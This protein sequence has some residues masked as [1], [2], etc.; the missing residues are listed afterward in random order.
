MLKRKI[1][2]DLIQW[3]NRRHKQALLVEGARQVGKTT[4]IRSF[5]KQHYESFIELNFERN[6][7]LKD[8]F[9]DDLEPKTIYM[10]MS[11][12]GLGP[13]KPGKT[14][15]FFDEIQSCPQARTAIKFLVEDGRYDFI[16]SGSLLGINYKDVSS[17]PVG[18]EE[19][20]RMYS[21]D[22]EEF[23]WANHISEDVTQELKQC[24]KDQCPIPA[25]IHDKM[26]KLYYQ[27]LIVGGMPNVV[28]EFI[29]TYDI[30]EVIRIQKD[31]IASYRDNISKY[32]EGKKAKVKEI[33]EAIPEQL[34]KKNQRFYFSSLTAE[35]ALR[36]Y[37]GAI[38]WLND[39]G[40]ASMCCNVTQPQ[41]PLSFNQKRNLFKLFI[42]DSGF[43]TAMSYGRIQPNILK[44][45]LT[46]NNGAV[47][48]NDVAA[49]ILKK[50]FDIYYY[51]CKKPLQ[52]EIDFLIQYQ[53][54]ILPIKVKSGDD[55]KKH[56]SLDRF[57]SQ[58][59]DMDQ[60]IVFC[61][62]NIEKDGKLL[63]LP[64]YMTGFLENE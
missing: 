45:E 37:E 20:I 6:P 56:P 7:K 26:M 43:L 2:S 12:M 16:E 60:A 30:N 25:F 54:G 50:G 28:N 24:F 22:F 32:A 1:E 63:Y 29:E 3:K 58:Y 15:I 4:S 59:A 23:M 31:I 11:A 38:T 51:D 5:A 39:A 47:V 17:Y 46:I 21:L 34:N 55:Y 57:M 33:F 49:G 41:L 44:G 19:H 61:K 53:G 48:E 10:N 9:M 8:I 52:M 35:P 40:I 13:M 14:L 27:Y 62:G 42:C 64:L 36:S 18:F